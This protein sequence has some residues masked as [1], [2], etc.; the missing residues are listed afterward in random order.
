MS[1]QGIKTYEFDSG[2]CFFSLA[3]KTVLISADLFWASQDQSNFFPNGKYFLIEQVRA[4]SAV[5][6]FGLER[7]YAG[8]E[9]T[10]FQLL[11]VPLYFGSD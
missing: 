11:C 1:R 4:I 8:I 6:K 3:A 5:P 10:Q 7:F 9:R 2:L